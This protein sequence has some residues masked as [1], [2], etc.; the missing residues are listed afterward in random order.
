MKP[1]RS[2]SPRFHIAGTFWSLHWF[3]SKPG[4]NQQVEWWLN[5][6][7]G[8]SVGDH[9]VFAIVITAQRQ[10]QRWLKSQKPQKK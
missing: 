10:Y 7:G 9:S 4:Y 6:F 3:F 2:A 8:V 5:Q 1:Y